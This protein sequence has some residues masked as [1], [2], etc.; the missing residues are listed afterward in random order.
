[1]ILLFLYE[2]KPFTKATLS[3]YS[4]KGKKSPLNSPPKSP[5][6]IIASPSK[7]SSFSPYNYFRRDRKRTNT[8]KQELSIMSQ[9]LLNSPILRRTRSRHSTVNNTDIIKLVPTPS[10]TKHSKFTHFDYNESIIGDENYSPIHRKDKKKLK[11]LGKE[12]LNKEEKKDNNINFTEAASQP[13]F[14]Q[15]KNDG[16]NN[17]NKD[18]ESISLLSGDLNDIKRKR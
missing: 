9:D 14:K 2:K 13:V 17:N 7:N 8:L 4:K 11:N 5:S 12:N 6:K 10:T 16:N 3:A 18:S 15:V 1:M